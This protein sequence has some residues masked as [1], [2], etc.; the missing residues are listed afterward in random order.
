M[1]R[2]SLTS[3]FFPPSIEL[4]SK[5]EVGIKHLKKNNTVSLWVGFSMFHVL[6]CALHPIPQWKKPLPDRGV[7]FG[8]VPSKPQHVAPGASRK[9]RARE[10]AAS[11]L[12][13]CAKIAKSAHMV[14]LCKAQAENTHTRTCTRVGTWTHGHTPRKI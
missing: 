12:P 7:S 9:G 3:T 11:L 8:V 10:S 2:G 13:N 1:T 4:F 5:Q 6:F 14:G